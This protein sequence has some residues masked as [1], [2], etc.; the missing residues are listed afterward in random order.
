M[1]RKIQNQW[2]FVNNRPRLKTVVLNLSFV[3]LISFVF[4]NLTRAVL[5]QDLKATPNVTIPDRF[6]SLSFHL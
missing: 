5:V 2:A 3:V 1:P 6:H 4:H